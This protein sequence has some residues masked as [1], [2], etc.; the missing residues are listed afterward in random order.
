MTAERLL[1]R[2][3]ISPYWAISNA[4]SWTSQDVYDCMELSTFL[5]TI[6]KTSDNC[7]TSWKD[8][9]FG[10]PS[11][12]L[13]WNWRNELLNIWRDFPWEEAKKIINALYKR[14]IIWS[15]WEESLVCLNFNSYDFFRD[16]NISVSIVDK[17]TRQEQCIIWFFI[18][19]EKT[20]ELQQI[21]W[22]NTNGFLIEQF[23]ELIVQLES[24]VTSL[25][26][27]RILVLKSS[28]NFFTNSPFINQD[29]EAWSTE[30]EDW[31]SKHRERMVMTYDARP[32][33]KWWY[34]KP[35]SQDDLD[36]YSAE[37]YI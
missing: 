35:R 7:M 30:E 15:L 16:T 21:Q 12:R 20:I 17:E 4:C 11:Q 26:F 31:L 3:Q 27:K 19:P 25:W 24:F 5:D 1:E 22:K 37:K 18:G 34:K 2:N 9:L 23:D 29:L 36:W 10:K 28:K 14:K 8:W 32:L 6:A 33:R 13:F